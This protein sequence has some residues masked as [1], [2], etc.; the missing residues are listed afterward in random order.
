MY[1]SKKDMF[2]YVIPAKKAKIVFL[3]PLFDGIDTFFNN[4]CAFSAYFCKHNDNFNN[5]ETIPI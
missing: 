4:T 1:L 2:L 3:E 5:I